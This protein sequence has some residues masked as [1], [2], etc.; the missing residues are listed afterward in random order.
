M[1]TP[2]SVNSFSDEEQGSAPDL[3]DNASWHTSRE[4]RRWL[5][6][7]IAVSKTAEAK[8]E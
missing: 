7:T 1:K 8:L 2:I 3:W 5:A 4:V 6:S